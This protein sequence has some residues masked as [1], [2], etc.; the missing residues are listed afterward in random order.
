MKYLSTGIRRC[1]EQGSGALDTSALAAKAPPVEPTS[2]PASTARPVGAFECP[3]DDDPSELIRRRWLCRGGIALLAGPTGIG[4]SSLTMQ[5]A[6]SWTLGRSCFGLKPRGPLR[7]MI[8]Q[9]ENDDGD[10]AEMRDGVYAGMKLASV[11]I[12]EANTKLYMVNECERTGL[13]FLKLLDDELTTHPRDLVFIDPVFSYLGGDASDQALV[14]GFLRNGLLPILR[15]HQ[16]GCILVHHTN[17]PP[18]GREK[19]NW[20]GGDFAYLG[21]GSA[22]WANAARAVLAMRS[23]GSHEKFQLMAGKRGGRLGWTDALGNRIYWKLIG[24][25]LRGICWHEL[26]PGELKISASAAS[27]KSSK[28]QSHMNHHGDK[29]EPKK[30]VRSP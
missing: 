28:D 13:L 26:D 19:P 2:P 17:K 16:C 15:K 6:V 12:A 22:E 25:S 8:I 27:S 10:V 7:V 23:I 4:K 20:K 1:P 11:D 29:P 3:G 30:C 5:L 24:H 18:S 9:G 14:S 21:S